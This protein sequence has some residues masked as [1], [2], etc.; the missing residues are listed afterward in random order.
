M[1]ARMF[2]LGACAAFAASAAN[3]HGPQIQITDT[4]N[5]ITTRELIL[6]DPYSD[7]LTNEK[8]VY[9][10][11]ILKAVTGS[12]STDY[13]TVMPN[14]DIDPIT[15]SSQ[16]QFG[17]GL[18]YGYGQTFDAGRHFNV[19]FVDSLKRWDGS[20]FGNNP[21]PE[22]IGAFQGDATFPADTAFTT[23]SAPYQGLVFSNI[24]AG[25]DDESHSYMRFRMLGDGTS[26]LS[27]ASDGIYLLKLQ[28]TSTQPGLD[29]SNV[30][31]FVLYKNATFSDLSA[32]VA[33]LGV[34]PSLVQF[35]GI[36]EP[37]AGA[38]AVGG[39]VALVLRRRARRNGGA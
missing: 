14:D 10:L 23:D 11:P 3:A 4:S 18:A 34:D 2:V 20:A 25:Y 27:E 35:V 33:A 8:S 24:T 21:G 26:A 28:I 19:N 7:S 22:E 30:M 17:P 15:G 29:P 32:A 9:V 13:W 39:F 6:D 16:F 36:P 12:P 31:S 1:R 5:K 37:T 38:L